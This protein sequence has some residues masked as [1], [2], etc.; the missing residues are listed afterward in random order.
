M[1]TITK[2]ELSRNPAKLSGIKPGESVTVRD[3]QGVLTVTRG[4][5]G[6]LTPDQIEAELQRICAQG[7]KTDALQMMGEET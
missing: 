4:K 7:P 1:K 6:L 5:S 3:R 2:R